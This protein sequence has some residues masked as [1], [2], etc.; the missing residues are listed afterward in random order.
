M[1]L[2]IIIFI[3]SILFGVVIYWRE[4]QGNKVYRFF[5]KLMN[6]KELQMKSTNKKG[7]VYQQ[8]L[9]LRLVFITSFF[10]IAIL[11][12]QFLIPIN[13]TAISLFASMIVGTLIG[14]YIASFIFKSSEI[15][16][17]QTESI[18][19]KFNEVVE[20]GKDFIED[21]QT[22]ETVVETKEEPKVEEKSAR[23]RLKD[24]GFLK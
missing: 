6:S 3:A 18:E 20:K 9:I 22:K 8:N 4:S 23:E 12:F 10:L 19:D 17:E 13:Y 7:F 21:L 2:E 1:T 11:V 15:I 14:T 5:N 24:K 16:E